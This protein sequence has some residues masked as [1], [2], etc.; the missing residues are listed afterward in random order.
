MVVLFVSPC[1]H[2]SADPGVSVS[3]LPNKKRL[4]RGKR[5]VQGSLP[6]ANAG[7]ST[8]LSSLE[9]R[10]TV[11]QEARTS[12]HAARSKRLL[13]LL[14]TSVQ[15]FSLT[16][17]EVRTTVLQDARTSVHALLTLLSTSVQEVRTTVLLSQSGR[18]I[19]LFAVPA[20]SVL[21]GITMKKENWRA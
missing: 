5:G 21:S 2:P 4:H 15:G 18:E 12:V 19:L 7:I 14:S 17:Q 6:Q 1:L 10:T 20:Q 16:R 13:T 11:L 3:P 8:L 9:V